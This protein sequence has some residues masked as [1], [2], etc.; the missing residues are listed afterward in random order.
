MRNNNIYIGLFICVCFLAACGG[1]QSNV[2]TGVPQFK[3]LSASTTGINFSNDLILDT[4]L[5]IFKYMY[6][7]NGGGV[8]AGD[9]NND[10][11]VD[12]FFTANQGA[13][14][15]FLNKGDL[16]FEEVTQQCNIVQDNA[17]SNGVCIVDINNDGLLDIY[18][19]QVGDFKMLKGRNQ[20]HVCQ[21]IKD[22]IPIYKEEALKYGL[23]ISG[24][25]TQATFFDFDQDGDL[26]L[27]QMMH[28]LHG[29][30]TFGKRKSFENK[31]DTLSGDKFYENIGGKFKEI[32]KASGIYSTVIGY[33][34]GLANADIDLDGD[35]DMYIGNDFHENDYLYINNGDKTFTEKLTQQ[36]MHTS[37]FSMGVDIADLNNDAYPEIIS[38]D[39]LPEDP[40][41]LKKSEGEDA[42]GIFQFKLGFGYNHQYA[43]NSLQLNNGNNTFSEIAMYAGVHATDWSW[44]ALFLDF[45]NDGKK[46]LFISNGIPK[47]MN[48]IDYINFMSD[49]D[50]QWRIRNDKLDKSDLSMIDKLPEIKLK[51]KFYRNGENLKF[52]DLENNVAN[53]KISYSNGA[54]YADLDNDGDLDIVTNNIDEG[55]FLYENVQQQNNDNQYFQL[56][57]KGASNNINAIGAKVLV[58]K[59]NEVITY[60][61]SITRGFQSSMEIPMHIGVGNADEIESILLIWPDHTYEEIQPTLNQTTEFTYKKGLPKYKHVAKKRDPILLDET[62]KIMPAAIHEENKYV[63]FNREPLIPHSSSSEGPALAVGDLN[64]DGLED[65]FLGGAKR[66]R[67]MIYYQT[68]SGKFEKQQFKFLERDSV[69]EDVDARILDLNG[70]QIND[71]LVIGAGN[72]W[73]NKSPWNTPRVYLNN[74]KGE[75]TLVEDAFPNMTMTFSCVELQDINS[76]G[77]IDVFLGGRTV[78]WAYGSIPT[79]YFY[80]NKGDGTFEDKTEEYSKDLQDIG[81]VKDAS[82]SDIDSDG[83][84]DLLLALEWGEIVLLEKSNNQFKRRNLTDEKGWWNFAFPIDIDHDGDLDILAGNLGL[85]SRLKASKDEPV[86]MYYNDYDDNG[87]KEQVL[88]Y[89]LQNKE[90]PFSNKMELEKQMPFLKKKY[91]YAKDFAQANL[92]DLFGDK[93]DGSIIHEADYM[94]NAVLINNGNLNFTL[95]DLPD[96]LQYTSYNDAFS[97]DINGD[98]LPDFLLGG[99]YYD[100]NIQMGRLDAD[101][102]TLVLNQGE[103]K[104]SKLKNQDLIIKGQIRTIKSIKIGNESYLLIGMNNEKLRLL[105]VSASAKVFG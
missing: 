30:G 77:K 64:G 88:S 20:L 5:N 61:K 33:G 26:D 35:Q 79:S 17:W 55:V 83:D 81:M 93:L 23:D 75:L 11:K 94:S 39:M 36:M 80:I 4:E 22:G 91:L 71:L 82:W 34:L 13:N 99:N 9:F 98:D 24:F 31:Y 103:G 72:E 101:Y 8:G 14:Q 2:I 40:Y 50:I 1:G 45:D 32:S 97:M 6:F 87:K 105:K 102:G 15:L 76:D 60:E 95:Q 59:K 29:N 73:Y 3:L 104:F 57:L 68:K 63:E 65:F 7:Y 44:G 37:R 10:G 96:N 66:K 43:K 12:L 74:S 27:Y 48:D 52:E 70:D 54:I 100:N 67:S 56:K 28:S 84:T 92:Q 62:D 42:Y 46:D 25:G 47:R 89:H 86:K 58:H 69:Y 41:I 16:Q 90:I 49:D 51:N 18:I 19:S 38:L 21:E 78:P 53:N 85:N